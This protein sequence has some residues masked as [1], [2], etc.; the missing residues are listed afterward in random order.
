MKIYKLSSATTYRGISGIF[1]YL[2]FAM[3]ASLPTLAHAQLAQITACVEV[4]QNTVAASRRRAST[5]SDCSPQAARDKARSQSYVNA[6]NALDSICQDQISQAEAEQICSEAAGA[7]PNTNT[8][9]SETPIARPGGSAV[10]SQL[11]VSQSDPKLCVVLRDLDDETVTSTQTNPVCVLD[12]FRETFVTFR[13]RA[14]CGVQCFVPHA[15]Q[16]SVRRHSTTQ[17]TNAN[18]DS[19]LAAATNILRTDSG[20]N[21]VACSVNLRRVNDVA[22]FTQ[23]DGSIDSQA[24]FNAMI[25]LRGRVKV[26]NAINWCGDTIPGIIGCAP[27]PGNSQLVVRTDQDLEGEVW[28]HEFG[29]TR[30]LPHRPTT[31]NNVGAVMFP[32]ALADNT[33]VNQTECSAYRDV[34]ITDGGNALGTVSASLD[35]DQLLESDTTD[36]K[37]FVKRLYIHGLP[38][39]AATRFG[40]ESVP[41]LLEVLANPKDE[42]HWSNAIITLAIIGDESVFER[43]RSFIEQPRSKQ[44][45]E[46]YRA[47]T[48][49]IMSLGYLLHRTKS[50]KVLQYLKQGLEPKAWAGKSGIGKA[51]YHSGIEGRHLDLAKYA[52]HGLALSGHPDAIKALKSMQ[53]SPTSN[54][55]KKLLDLKASMIAES[56]KTHETIAARGLIEYY[57]KP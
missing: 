15:H 4:P 6:R 53:Q 25:A 24:E 55:Q 47:R 40:P 36:I 54:E 10:Q 52:I 21:D 42:P 8:S 33:R 35:K 39:E 16:L 13:S 29:H 23:G 44:T 7:M 27:A 22:V 56:L 48:A 31:P 41:A 43:I 50:D 11:S 38:Y 26:V 49:A 46:S 14:R 45:D 9:L 32:M 19:I 20:A 12:G 1:G 37:Q 2:L 34:E 57:R 28:A 30:G 18:A 17:I 5:R 3:Q 51:S